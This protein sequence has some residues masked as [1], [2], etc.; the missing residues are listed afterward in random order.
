M[1]VRTV[2]ALGVAAVRVDAHSGVDAQVPALRKVGCHA[3]V[4]VLLPHVSDAELR[5]VVDVVRGRR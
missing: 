4:V 1:K 3:A 5:D 2:P